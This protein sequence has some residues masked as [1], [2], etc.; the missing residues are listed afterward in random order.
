[1]GSLTL[2]ARR[3]AHYPIQHQRC[4]TLQGG[5]EEKLNSSE[6]P[7]L[8]PNGIKAGSTY[9]NNNGRTC[10]LPNSTVESSSQLL[11]RVTVVKI[12][13]REVLPLRQE[14]LHQEDDEQEFGKQ[15]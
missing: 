11:L 7:R 2:K 9:A 14:G 10:A 15:Q 4:Q 1:M 3:T 12:L 8:S 5:W 6:N 13:A